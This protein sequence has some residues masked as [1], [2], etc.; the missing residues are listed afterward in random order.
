M[1]R[2]FTELELNLFEPEPAVQSRVQPEC[3][4]RTPVRS[5]VQR[6]VALNRTEPNFDT[7]IP[8]AGAMEIF[9]DSTC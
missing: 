7:T 5:G 4:N 8:M 3:Q 9:L 6:K 1:V 2:T